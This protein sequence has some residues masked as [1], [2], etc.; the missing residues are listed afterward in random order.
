MHCANL[1][2]MLYNN[3]V[4]KL[5]RDYKSAKLHQWLVVGEEI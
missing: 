4:T 2:Y 5:H 1:T 3:C